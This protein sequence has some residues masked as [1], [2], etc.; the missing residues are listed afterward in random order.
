MD[1]TLPDATTNKW[2]QQYISE[3]T[4]QQIDYKDITTEQQTREQL[5]A[6][7]AAYLEPYLQQ[8]MKRVLAQAQAEAAEA[9]DL[10]MMALLA[11]V[12]PAAPAL[13]LFATTDKI[14]H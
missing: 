7:E 10:M 14:E 3:F 4:P 2:Y 5:S 13:L 6:S 9:V 12:E 11:V 1:A 8:S